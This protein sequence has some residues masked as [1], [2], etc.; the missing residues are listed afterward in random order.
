MRVKGEGDERWGVG[1]GRDFCQNKVL[2]RWGFLSLA[3]RNYLI[4][5][6]DTVGRFRRA[7]NAFS[8]ACNAVEHPWVNREQNASLEIFWHRDLRILASSGD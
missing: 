6:R 3:P 2:V 7:A 1:G 8:E 4:R 5:T